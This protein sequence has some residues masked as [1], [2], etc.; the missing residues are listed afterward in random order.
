MTG[1]AADGDP[2]AVARVRDVGQ[3]LAGVDLPELHSLRPT[4][5]PQ[6]LVVAHGRDRL[7]TRRVRDVRDAAVVS[8]QRRQLAVGPRGGADGL[9]G[10]RRV[11]RIPRLQAEEQRELRVLFRRTPAAWASVRD[12]ARCSRTDACARSTSATTDSRLSTRPIAIAPVT[13][14]RW[15]LVSSRRDASTNAAWAGVGSGLR[16]CDASHVSAS[17]SSGPRS[18][19]NRLRSDASHSLVRTSSRVC[20]CSHSRSVSSAVTI[21]RTDVSKSSNSRRKIQLIAPSFSAFRV[22]RLPDDDGDDA[23]VQREC[24]V[25]PATALGV[26]E[27]WP[28]RGPRRRHWHGRAR[29]RGPR[30]SDATPAGC[31][32]DAL[33]ATEILRAITGLGDLKTAFSS[34]LRVSIATACLSQAA[35][36]R[37]HA[38]TA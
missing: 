21:D 6:R 2:A 19:F 22:A 12:V 35:Q 13:V 7:V 28:A 8:D 4:P 24:G 5:E 31:V 32:R 30:G 37:A 20:A 26:G 11:L 38:I 1:A 16:G 33:D 34:V 18:S 3:R 25:E 17:S 27:R 10:L 15:R 23:L 14:L 9:L 36:N 29:R